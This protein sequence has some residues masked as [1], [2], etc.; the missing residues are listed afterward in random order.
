MQTNTIFVRVLENVNFQR[1]SSFEAWIEQFRV[2]KEREHR[3]MLKDFFSSVFQKR[4]FRFSLGKLFPDFIE[5]FVPV[6]HMFGYQFR[7]FFC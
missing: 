6:F 4:F 2:I 3:S 1:K 5:N 7:I